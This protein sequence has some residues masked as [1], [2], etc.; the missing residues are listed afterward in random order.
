LVER[1]IKNRLAIEQKRLQ[2]QNSK[3]VEVS[4][5]HTPPKVG[6]TSALIINEEG[7]EDDLPKRSGA[8]I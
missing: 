4:A 7:K 2:R 6:N 8:T 3:T 5:H 1:K